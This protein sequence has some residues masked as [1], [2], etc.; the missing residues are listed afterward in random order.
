MNSV[1][2]RTRSTLPLP[3]RQDV[4]NMAGGFGGAVSRVTPYGGKIA[5]FGLP[6]AFF[7]WG[8]ARS[9][10]RSASAECGDPRPPKL[11]LRRWRG[12]INIPAVVAPARSPLQ[13]QGTE[14][15]DHRKVPP[16]VG[17]SIR[18]VAGGAPPP[19]CADAHTPAYIF[20]LYLL[21]F[22]FLLFKFLIHTPF[23]RLYR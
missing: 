5:A 12:D 17:R 2:S 4:L 19:P 1:W 15:L 20:R 14:V 13:E 9:S 8:F 3:P 18:A 10:K 16:S 22:R 11:F 6:R 21:V 7:A 23:W